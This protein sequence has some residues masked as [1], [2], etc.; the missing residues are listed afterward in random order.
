MYIYDFT[1]KIYLPADSVYEIEATI[2]ELIQRKWDHIHKHGLE[3][4]PEIS[5]GFVESQTEIPR[6]AVES[7][8]AV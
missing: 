6:Y 3:A 7:I 5:F 4:A 8:A 2:K 1:Q